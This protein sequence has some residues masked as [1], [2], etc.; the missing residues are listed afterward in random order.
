MSLFYPLI[1]KRCG[2]DVKELKLIFN[3]FWTDDLQIQIQKGYAEKFDFVVKFYP[4]KQYLN[5]NGIHVKRIDIKKT[6]NKYS[7]DI[8]Y[9]E[10]EQIEI[11]IMDGGDG[12]H[13]SHD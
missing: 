7:Y 4:I 6:D 2:Y 8:I 11:V 5:D 12:V 1:L 10:S 9:G 13:S 3:G